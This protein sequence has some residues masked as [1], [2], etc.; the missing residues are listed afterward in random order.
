MDYKLDSEWNYAQAYL[1]RIDDCFILCNSCKLQHNYSGWFDAL[2]ALYDELAAQ[3]K[4]EAPE[5][6]DSEVKTAEEMRDRCREIINNASSIEGSIL[7]R[8]LSDFEI[9]LRRIMKL[10]GMDLPRKPDPSKAL[11]E[12]RG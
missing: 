3:M 11:M 10:R 7:Q 8:R 1:K 2:L 6:I 9:Y 5:G 4:T 12:S